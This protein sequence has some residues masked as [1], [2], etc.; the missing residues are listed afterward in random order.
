MC[1][2]LNW[3]QGQSRTEPGRLEETGTNNVTIRSHI[4]AVF[5]SSESMGLALIFTRFAMVL[6]VVT[7][8][9][10]FREVF[11]GK[12]P[13]QQPSYSA[14]AALGPPVAGTQNDN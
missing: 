8:G 12:W 7:N 9:F 10:D 4:A 5:K 6:K 13:F 11:L 14:V 1:Q 3:C 2:E